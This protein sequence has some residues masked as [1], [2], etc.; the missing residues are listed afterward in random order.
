MTGTSDRIETYLEQLSQGIEALG[1]NESAEV[2]AEVRAHLAE[3]VADAGGDE[4]A[5]LTVFGSA[6]ALAARILEERGVFAGAGAL[7]Q[8]P[9]G[10]QRLA[11]TVDILL[12]LAGVIAVYM[13]AIYIGLESLNIFEPTP[14]VFRILTLTAWALALAT[15]AVLGR[16]TLK[17]RRTPGAP[18]AGMRLLGLRRIRFGQDT[19]VVRLRQVPGLKRPSLLVPTIAVVAGLVVVFWFGWMWARGSEVTAEMPIVTA[20][21]DSAGAVRTLTGLYQR[22]VR[23]MD[24]AATKDTFV[25]AARAAVAELTARQKAGNVAAYSIDDF[26]FTNATPRAGLPAPGKTVEAVV[27]VYEYGAISETIHT[28]WDYRMRYGEVTD[29]DGSSGWGWRIIAVT[30]SAVVE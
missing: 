4:E 5:V 1:P 24:A 2:T 11:L 3:A 9:A 19:R 26:G 13:L 10:R 15:A 20:V 18:S 30:P 7:P 29:A 12:W 8:A 23:G 22:V 6:D 28:A 21:Q 16:W 27:T 14:V 17:V 25:P